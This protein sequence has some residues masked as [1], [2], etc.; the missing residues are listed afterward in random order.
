MFLGQNY[1]PATPILADAYERAKV[2][3]ATWFAARWYLYNQQRAPQGLPHTG[4]FERFEI[5]TRKAW[6]PLNTH[7]AI[8][9][10]DMQV[11]RR[12]EYVRR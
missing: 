4:I 12:M 7:D 5:G 2:R 1:D 3:E 11:G 10:G 8:H 6:T 9:H